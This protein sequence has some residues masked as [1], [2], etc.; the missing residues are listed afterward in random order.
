MQLNVLGKKYYN[1]VRNMDSIGPLLALLVLLLSLSFLSEHFFSL[2]NFFNIIQQ[3]SI[4]LIIA[5]GMTVVII[6]S[7]I[8]LSVGSV[9][10]LTG[11]SIAL[12]AVK[13]GINPVLAILIGLLLGS[14][15]GAF[16]GFVISRTGIPDFIMTLG[17]LSAAKGLALVIT[18]GLPVTGLPRLLV[19]FGSTKLFGFLP[20]SGVVA[21]FMVVL[22]WFILN[23]TKLGR[24]A[25]AIGGN[26]EAAQA[27]GINVK[28]Y[29]IKIYALLG[30]FVAV[31]SLVQLGRI[32]SANPLMGSGKELQAI[33]AVIIGGTNLFGGEGTIGGTVI[34]A[35]IMG[36][37]S[38]GL[39][40]L[41]VS[42]FW[43]EFFIG[44]LIVL[45]VVVDQ[46]KRNR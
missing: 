21:V 25:Y 34:G 42:S 26:K 23:Y 7:G 43:Q 31:A 12:L 44:S 5:L 18:G 6:S 39:N 38:N 28:N 37:L 30:F 11:S 1:K 9:L 13:Y 2:N 4:N 22:A 10:A 40:L 24:A 17:M 29:K 45:V 3:S 46:L 36:V 33:A 35:L 19:Y 41:N 14:L 15:I 32:Y 8:D 20:M 16:N 27:A